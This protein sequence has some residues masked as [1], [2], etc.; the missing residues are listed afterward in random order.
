MIS[1]VHKDYQKSNK[2]NP[3]GNMERRERFVERRVLKGTD[4]SRSNVIRPAL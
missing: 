4:D 1:Y 3:E 2:T